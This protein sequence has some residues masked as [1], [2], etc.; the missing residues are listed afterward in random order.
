MG[1]IATFGG[2]SPISGNADKPGNLLGPHNLG[3]IAPSEGI[4][5]AG[6][7]TQ[8]VEDQNPHPMLAVQVDRGHLPGQLRAQWWQGFPN[9]VTYAGE[10]HWL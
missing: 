9:A 7:V 4:P 8:N 1:T 3:P 2:H 10:P 5:E 6:S